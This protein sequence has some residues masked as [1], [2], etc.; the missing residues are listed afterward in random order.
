MGL[1]KFVCINR[2]PESSPGANNGYVQM[3]SGIGF[4]CTHTPP[5][6]PGSLPV[7]VWYSYSVG[8]SVTVYGNGKLEKG[9]T[10]TL[11]PSTTVDHPCCGIDS[12]RIEVTV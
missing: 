1:R 4:G 10:Y 2:V 7:S 8:Y 11:L 12:S 3:W 9:R 6:K 5:P